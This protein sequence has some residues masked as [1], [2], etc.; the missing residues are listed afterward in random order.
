LGKKIF[1]YFSSLSSAEAAA[2]EETAGDRGDCPD[3]GL[4]DEGEAAEAAEAEAA[5]GPQA[6]REGGGAG[7]DGVGVIVGEGHAVVMALDL[8]FMED[9]FYL[10]EEGEGGGGV[11]LGGGGLR[12]SSSC[13]GVT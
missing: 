7:L 9:W 5:G 2:A 6:A 12:F 1:F 11:G 13:G 10:R 8:C 3:D 4:D